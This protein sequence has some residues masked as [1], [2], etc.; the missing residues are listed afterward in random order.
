LRALPAPRALLRHASAYYRPAGRFAWHFAQ[1]KLAGDPAFRTILAE[2]LLAQVQDVLDLGAG[3][4]LLAAW[5]LAARATYASER[6]GDWPRGWPAP[7]PLRSYTGIEINPQEVRRARRAFAHDSGA[8][9]RIVHADIREADYGTPDAVVLL[10]V[11]HYSDFRTQETILRR[12]RAALVAEGVLVLR[13]GDAA[14]GLGC[15]LSKAVDRTVALARRGRWL[16]LHCRTL[17]QW[18][19]LL[20]A[21]G[22]TTRAVP[23]PDAT[24]FSNVLLVA[25]RT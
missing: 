8:A 11:L 1:G 18:Q 22:F 12:V 14:G 9:V 4:A 23:M 25:R 20:A 6:A 2:G 10:D 5:L 7:P 3:Q 21:L 15:A 16:P 19:Q 24:L 13:V 17:R